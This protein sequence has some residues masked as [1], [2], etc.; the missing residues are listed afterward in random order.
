MSDTLDVRMQEAFTHLQEV[1]IRKRKYRNKNNPAV[2][3]IRNVIENKPLNR[4]P[5]YGYYKEHEKVRIG[6]VNERARLL[7]HPAVRLFPAL[8]QNFDSVRIEGRVFLPLYVQ[9]LLNEYSGTE[10]HATRAGQRRDRSLYP[11]SAG[12]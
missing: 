4:N 8:E 12:R 3:L 6:L 5:L 7:K 1:K 9:E 10:P 2:E 11:E